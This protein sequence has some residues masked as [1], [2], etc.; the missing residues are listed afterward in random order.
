VEADR[1]AARK[2]GWSRGDR[3]WEQ[4]QE[5]GNT[6]LRA[7]DIAAAQKLWR[8]AWWVA[9]WRFSWRDMRWATTLANLALA[10]RLAGRGDRA[11]R[12]YARARRIWAGADGFIATMRVAPRPRSA[13]FPMQMAGRHWDTYTQN[14]RIRMTVFTRATATALAALEQG[15]PVACQL[16][17]RWKAEKPAVF[18]DTRRLL[19]A[20]L[21]IATPPG[22]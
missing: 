16:Y 12:R 15:Q 8:Q 1:A 20:A 21:L 6:Q 17:S 19:A 13:L 5:Q 11:R 10:D 7:G 14:A 9:L 3:A 2:A 4:L 18:D 22:E